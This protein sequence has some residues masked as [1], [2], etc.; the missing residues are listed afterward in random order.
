MQGFSGGCLAPDAPV[1]TEFGSGCPIL[2]C[3][4]P[5]EE[6]V[7]KWLQL[8]PVGAG[9]AVDVLFI[10]HGNSRPPQ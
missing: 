2:S 9:A 3:S 4:F 1:Q 8:H 6:V 7:P 5:R 10:P